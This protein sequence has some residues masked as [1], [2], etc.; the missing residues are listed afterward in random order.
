MWAEIAWKIE[1]WVTFVQVKTE[2]RR[3]TFKKQ[4]MLNMQPGGVW[5]VGWGFVKEHNCF[6]FN[7][8]DLKKFPILLCFGDSGFQCVLVLSL[9]SVTTHVQDSSL[10]WE[11][12][13]TLMSLGL[14][15]PKAWRKNP[16]NP[17]IMLD[18]QLRYR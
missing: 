4:I 13:G 10:P 11:K 17:H 9:L 12:G 5:F 18:L 2:R 7:R 8:I 16:P 15:N 1:R 14:I 3:V 6:D